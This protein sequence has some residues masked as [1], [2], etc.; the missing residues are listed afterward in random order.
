MAFYGGLL[1]LAVIEKGEVEDVGT[2]VGIPGAQ[3]RA[4][5]M[6]LGD[7]RILELLQYVYP[8]GTVIRQ[9]PNGIGCLHMAFRVDDIQEVLATLTQ[10]G[11]HAMGT[12][13]TITGTIAWHGATVVYLRDPDGALVELI[14][15][16]GARRQK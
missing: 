7:G 14:Q 10:A 4:A 5:D 9:E 12:P 16:P 2:V 15:R 6:D 1:G 8:A 13:T 11:H 3:L